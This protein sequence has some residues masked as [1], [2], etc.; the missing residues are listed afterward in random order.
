MKELEKSAKEEKKT[1]KENHDLF[2]WEPAD[3]EIKNALD[4]EID[5]HKD[6][7][8]EDFMLGPMNMRR[9]T[10]CVAGTFFQKYALRSFPVDI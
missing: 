5:K 10:T 6:I 2:N 4:V 7:E 8:Y 1:E 3:L 9:K